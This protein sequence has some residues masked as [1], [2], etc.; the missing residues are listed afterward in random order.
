MRRGAAVALAAA[1]LALGGCSE[2]PTGPEIQ[3]ITEV[4]YA[5]S[6]GIDLADYT[7]LA[8]GV[9]IRDLTVGT[10]PVVAE[11]SE[12][13][14]DYTGWLVDGTQFDTGT[15]P[16]FGYLVDR[17]IPGFEFG[18]EGIA[19]GGLRRMIIPSDLA[20]GTQG[21]GPIPPGAILIFE[22]SATSI[23]GP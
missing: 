12:I 1:V 6:L 21:I 5:S 8:S 13:T 15:L 7:E 10:G 17:L 19:E 11:G 4:T 14:L 23:T 20:Y 2:E 9:W 3:V 22:V 18:L 16:P